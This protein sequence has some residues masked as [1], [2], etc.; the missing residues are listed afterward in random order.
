[1]TDRPDVDR[2]A[3]LNGRWP[4][5]AAGGGAVEIASV[6]VQ[7]RPERLDEVARAIAA[8]PGSDVHG[9]SALGKLVV[10]I[11]AADVGAI[12][13]TLNTISS[14]PHVL[15]AALVFHGTDPGA[16]PATRD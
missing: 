13:A 2:R 5:P 1:M 14:M 4:A 15:T 16:I 11:E 8:L 9:R 3:F 10:V 7:A 6:L 12:G